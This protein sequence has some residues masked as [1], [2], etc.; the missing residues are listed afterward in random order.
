[1]YVRLQSGFVRA[2]PEGR[3]LYYPEIPP[4]AEAPAAQ[5]SAAD[6]LEFKKGDFSAAI[7]AVG[8][9]AD[10]ADPQIAAAARVRVARN[11]LK[12]G[13]LPEA[14]GAYEQL[15]VLG[16][17]SVGG[18]PAPLAAHIGRMTVL[19]RQHDDA[20]LAAS[21][22]WLSKA[23]RTARW[24][25]SLATYEYLDRE[26]SRWLPDNE[27]QHPPQLALAEGVNWLWEERR[28][29][30][31]TL[32]S[33]RTAISSTSGSPLLVWRGSEKEVVAF[34]ADEEYL[35]RVWLADL[36][37]L[38]DARRARVVL[39]TPT[40]QPVLGSASGQ[41]RATV[42]L[43]STTHLPWTIEI[44]SAGN[45]DPGMRARRWLLV[46]GM[47]V[48]IGLVFTGAWFVD[49]T[50][51]RELAVAALKSDFVSA[52]SHEFR[53]PL[54]TLCQLSELLMRAR[55]ASEADRRQY[56]EL[57]YADSQR[58]RRLVETLLNFGRLEAGRMQFRFEAVDPV[59][60][61]RETAEQFSQSDQAR[62]HT[63]EVEAPGSSASISADREM[64]RTVLWNL[65]ENSAKY[66][67][68]CTTI[69][70][71]LHSTDSHVTVAIRDR[72]V[73][74]PKSEQTRVF[75]TFGRGSAACASGVAG[76]GVGLAMAQRIV[77][78]HGGEIRLDSEV[79]K[80]STFAVVLPT[81][82]ES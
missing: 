38:I 25:V 7:A 67:P 78:A 43:A 56:Y 52:I 60:I 20:A 79:G 65:F 27:R 55:V 66:S 35:D 14:A 12:S 10:A 80:G 40:G 69:W 72:G 48:L 39:M 9:R 77:H 73:G 26:A 51:E 31:L 71:A 21:A 41:D 76:T 4:A 28:A 22:R 49:R 33:G 15:A 37:P 2:W 57:L 19:E 18:M 63:V 11:L 59:V 45:D 30:D 61:L 6:D 13:K 75:D 16:A 29:N 81:C 74:I 46:A 32:P 62:G 58:L 23:L 68:D 50:V 1:V 53:T 34:V 47:T 64:F 5:F 42:R 24:P 8:A 3:L 82:R 54:T 44:S 70:A 17:A 36:G